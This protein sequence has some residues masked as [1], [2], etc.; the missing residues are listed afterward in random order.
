MTWAH[1]ALPTQAVTST[2]VEEAELALCSLLLIHKMSVTKDK[3]PE[4]DPARGWHIQ[5]MPAD[6]FPTV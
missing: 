5:G 3:S 6:W 1:V 4:E 2:V